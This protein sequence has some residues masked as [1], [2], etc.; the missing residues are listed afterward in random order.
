MKSKLSFITI[1]LILS[2]CPVTSHASGSLPGIGVPTEEAAADADH[3][4]PL[5]LE[6]SSSSEITEIISDCGGYIDEEARRSDSVYATRR[7]IILGALIEEYPDADLVITYPEFNETILSFPTEQDTHRAYD[8]LVDIYGEESCF[9][10]KKFSGVNLLMEDTGTTAGT[11]YTAT[12][13]GTSDMGMDT[14]KSTYREYSL[15][16][17]TV[18]LID[19]GVNTENDM[20]KRRTITGYNTMTGSD[21]FSDQVSGLAGHGTHVCGIVADATAPTVDL[22]MISPF[23]SEANNTE[24]SLLAA[25]QYALEHG[26]D[27]IN[28]SLGY[29]SFTDSFL[30]AVIE[31]AYTR[32]VPVVTSAGNERINVERVYPASNSR[33]LAISG[34]RQTADSPGIIYDD[35][36]SA[37]GELIDFAGPGT[38]ITSADNLPGASTTVKKGTSM[39]APHITAALCWIK[40]IFPGYSVP[41][42][43]KKLQDYCLDL[44]EKGKDIY[45]GN[46]Y[47]RIRTLLEDAFR[48]TSES[49]KTSGS[50]KDSGKTASAAKPKT[51]GR[52]ADVRLKKTK[53]RSLKR[54]SAK[55]IKLKWK[56]V[57]GI[58][59]YQIC[60]STSKT[61]RK[62]KKTVWIKKQKK[63]S[64]SIGKLKRKKKYYVRI[65]TYKKVKKKKYYSTWSNVRSIRT[66]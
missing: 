9:I 7:I 17:V 18:A 36:Y 2:F 49:D 39:A 66:K 31:S 26:A 52:T 44:G 64:C 8:T 60:Y 6:V 61:F 21:D 54:I 15:S 55:K 3:E 50:E 63:T 10:D 24:S 16:D 14:L 25:F 65:R 13:W 62:N 34:V 53:L 43:Y 42:L 46:G 45:Y 5:H 12:S 33:T 27:I 38:A 32:N 58:S 59:G 35:S 48:K 40:M 57:Y 22:M 47:P 23:D 30:D 11:A 51:I 28:L 37:Y 1:L 29:T 20:F 56:K 4:E 19:T 41:Q